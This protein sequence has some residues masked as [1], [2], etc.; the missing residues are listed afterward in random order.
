MKVS[1][2]KENLNKVLNSMIE[3]HDLLFDGGPVNQELNNQMLESIDILKKAIDSHEGVKKIGWGAFYFGG[4]LRGK[5]Y[6][7]C[8][9]KEQIEL[10]I[11]DVHRSNDSI[12]LFPA[13]IYTDHCYITR[14][15]EN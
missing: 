15:I 13:P 14:Q 9:T 4:K 3:A 10:Y 2:D 11:A 1:I 5:L 7:Q 12:T 6:S 8:E